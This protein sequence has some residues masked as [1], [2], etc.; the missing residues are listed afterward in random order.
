[1]AMSQV[2]LAAQL[3]ALEPAAAEAD[4]V[5]ALADAY[6]TFAADAQ[7]GTAAITAAGVALGKAAMLAALVGMSAPGAG[8]AVLTAAVQAFWGAVAG[9][10]ATSFPAATAIVPPPHS[11]LQALLDATFTSNTATAA[12]G[13]DATAAVA[14][15]LYGQAI[16]GGG[17]TFPGPVVSP[18]T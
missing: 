3:L 6:A 1:M 15:D 11:G 17:V 5:S 7:A 13:P 2:V 14:A 8:S 9:G 10:L 16:T 12:S 18:I 4:A